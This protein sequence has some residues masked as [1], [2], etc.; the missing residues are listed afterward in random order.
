MFRYE[1]RGVLSCVKCA[2]SLL[3]SGMK[4]E[5]VVLRYEERVCCAQV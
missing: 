1:E 2:E 5:F 3:C 4:R